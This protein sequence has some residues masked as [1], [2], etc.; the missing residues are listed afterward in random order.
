MKEFLSDIISIPVLVEEIGQCI[1]A[2]KRD[3]IPVSVTERIICDADTYHFGTPEFKRTDPLIRKEI[4]LLT[5]SDQTG[6]TGIVAELINRVSLSE[7][8]ERKTIT[9]QLVTIR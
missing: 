5:G 1:M 3:S 2:T 4:E 6:W 9:E 7:R 8:T